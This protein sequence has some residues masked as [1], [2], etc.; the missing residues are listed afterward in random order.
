[1]TGFEVVLLL[2][3]GAFAGA[4]NAIAGGG[5]MLSI[6][7]LVLAGVPGVVAN[8]SN[9]VGILTSTAASLVSYRREG[10]WASG[11]ELAPILM[12]AIVGSVLGAYAIGNF[13][14]E[15]FE[16]FFGLLMIPIIILSI[17]KPKVSTDGKHWPVPITI[18]VFFVIGIY[19]GAVQAGVGLVL[20][21]AISRAGFDL[22]TA[23]VIKVQFNVLATLMALPVFIMQG[24]VRWLPAIVIAVGLSVGGW[25]GAK[26]AVR[27]GEKWIR[28]VMV[29][30]ALGLAGRLLGLY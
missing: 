24:N 2:V 6:P 14:D 27:G 29:V 10:A 11:R 4:I 26:F 1:M 23:N 21:A 25:I 20:L 15:G 17:L 19:A 5:S 12:P 9:R 28:I 18:A 3:G 16:R 30:A 13:T 8:G 7:L 22:V